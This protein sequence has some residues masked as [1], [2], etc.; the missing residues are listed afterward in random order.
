MLH[1]EFLTFARLRRD[2]SLSHRFRNSPGFSLFST[3]ARSPDFGWVWQTRGQNS[4]PARPARRHPGY[5][6]NSPPQKN[7][8]KVDVLLSANRANVKCFA[9]DG[10]SPYDAW[11]SYMMQLAL[12]G[13]Q[14][15]WFDLATSRINLN[16][17]VC[18]FSASST[19]T[20]DQRAEWNH[21]YL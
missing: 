13:R 3:A 15:E 12:I 8:K 21:F 20:A 19:H 9:L 14:C 10:N 18:I 4:T 16:C 1:Y 17:A 7:R 11:A 6:K 5:R 2:F